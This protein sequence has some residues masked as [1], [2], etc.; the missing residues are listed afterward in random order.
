M[1]RYLI[2]MTFI[3]SRLALAE[4][5]YFLSSSELQ[6]LTKTEQIS[7]FR[8]V[9]RIIVEM[10]ENSSYM[11]EAS[12]NGR[13][14]ASVDEDDM[15]LMRYLDKNNI[16]EE[17]YQKYRNIAITTPVDKRNTSEYKKAHQIWNG[18]NTYHA[19]E[20]GLKKSRAL[21][22]AAKK[23]RDRKDAEENALKEKERLENEARYAEWRKNHKIP[24]RSVI[25]ERR[26]QQQEA[27]KQ[28][29]IREQ[30]KVK[31][32]F[33]MSEIASTAKKEPNCLFAGWVL[34]TDRCRGP[35]EF[36][37]DFNIPGV[38]REKMKCQNGQF[39]CQP[40]LFGLKL[41]Q[42]CN[43]LKDCADQ[44]RP[45]CVGFEAAITKSCQQK[46]FSTTKVAV[47]LATQKDSKLFDQY[48][49]EFYSLCDPDMLS[50]NSRIQK[51]E[52]LRIDVER[53]CKVASQKLQSLYLQRV[54]SGVPTGDS[55]P[56]SQQK[57]K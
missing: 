48:R 21:N 47:E 56:S 57:Q 35:Q 54:N 41:P 25:L 18:F 15:Y 2:V 43:F 29:K 12:R 6:Q 36:P 39:L 26:K 19:N 37:P 50:R 34:E 38:D 51:R 3:L 40:L 46:S 5:P 55:K 52:R 7:Y 31:T 32:D 24:P 28:A 20:V 23:E 17:Q 10:S 49:G 22:E 33:R 11:A 4:V 53:T 8:E 30:E 1:N 42:G 9:Q 16:T 14:I 45:L 44:A 13:Q 27:N